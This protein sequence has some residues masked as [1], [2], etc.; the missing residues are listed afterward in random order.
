MAIKR[1]KL[2]GAGQQGFSFIELMA[3]LAILTLVIG[4]VVK[5]VTTMQARNT[6]E[7][8]KLDLTQ[9]S[10]EF[11]DQIVND[12]HQ[13]GF[14][15]IGMFDPA[16]LTSTT[17][18]TSD[19]NVACGLVSVSQSTVQFEGDV[20]ATGVSEVFIQLVQTNGA[21]APACTTPPCVMQRGTISKALCAPNAT[22][23][24]TGTAPQY[25]TEVNNVMNTNIFTAFLK[26]GTLVN[27]NPSASASDLPN[28]KAV[29]ITLYVRASQPDPQTGLLPTVTMVSTAE[30]KD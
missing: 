16:T 3:S 21:N 24:C 4:V 12:L 9:E 7:T 6:V 10:R 13:S 8:S 29:G 20:D 11:M 30:L 25:F 19:N 27:L 14:P 23:A 1:T 22:G 18:C 28:I 2:D 26:D 5:G 15:R 17:A